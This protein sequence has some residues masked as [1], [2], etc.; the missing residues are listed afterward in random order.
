MRILRFGKA[1]LLCINDVAYNI[2]S[3]DDQGV[4]VRTIGGS[5]HTTN[6]THEKIFTMYVN[7]ELRIVRGTIEALPAGVQNN[8]HK[9][10]EE[11]CPRDRA[12]A[13]RRYEYVLAC[14]KYFS[15][16][17][18]SRRPEGYAEIAKICAR[19]RR[20]RAFLESNTGYQSMAL[21]A[22]SGST[23][24]DWYWRYHKS[25]RDIAA[26][27]PLH[28][29]KGSPIT[30]VDPEVMEVVYDRVV[31]VW[32]TTERPPITQVHELIGADIDN[33][34]RDRVI[35]L[36]K[37][38]ETWLR[39]WVKRNVTEYE[40]VYFR[41][42]KNAAELKFGNVRK[43]YIPTRPLEEVELDHT[44]LDILTKVEEPEQ[45]GDKRRKKKKTVR[46]WLTMAICVA[47]RMII[48]WH[49]DAVAPGWIAVMSCL[50]MAIMP[51][52]SSVYGAKTEN[53]AVGLMER[54]K[55]D[56][57]RVEHSNSIIAFASQAGIALRWCPRAKG[58]LKPHIERA[59]GTVSRDFT[60]FLPGK[61]FRDVREKGDYR[62]DLRAEYT[63]AEVRH[64]FGYYICEIYHN[65]PHRG[66][67]KQTPLQRWRDLASVG[68][69]V[70]PSYEELR[71]IAGLVVPR[72]VTN[73]GVVFLGL[74]YQSD[75]LAAAHKSGGHTGKIYSVKVDP[76]DMSNV[77]VLDDIA[78]KWL[79]VP[80]VEKVLTENLSV[81]EWKEV[82]A[83]ARRQVAEN[84]RVPMRILRAA[85]RELQE[86][87]RRK[88]NRP[89]RFTQQDIDVLQREMD[90][91]FSIDTEDKDFS[92]TNSEPVIRQRRRRKHAAKREAERE[93]NS[94]EF[95]PSVGVANSEILVRGSHSTTTENDEVGDQGDQGDLFAGVVPTKPGPSLEGTDDWGVG[96]SD[97]D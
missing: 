67:F 57:G 58:K 80:A 7:R 21:E 93:I 68:T 69:R 84:S 61:V 10:L 76:L 46:V 40:R 81:A 73:K 32:L 83:L 2:V 44:Y 71:A 87:A 9:D 45:S 85:R 88:G 14:N 30:S 4:T 13:M 77:F 28:R 5:R 78:H 11:F 66:L 31:N 36:D 25:G 59:I 91:N 86:E 49:I 19:L 96:A 79:K 55:L 65:R 54:L 48:G 23:L 33:L 51:K 43:T 95:L 29:Q 53:P 8:L 82:T 34:N 1:D 27:V 52:D 20:L 12:E 35:E 39:L 72:A 15:E 6:F 18:F 92:G 22:V 89:I 42:G 75:E 56:N 16:D 74:Q 24:R 3:K 47:T 63:L 97:H 38:S 60:A 90:D 41:E 62:S 94:E 26:L 70:P 50:Q 37:P 64:W 17:K